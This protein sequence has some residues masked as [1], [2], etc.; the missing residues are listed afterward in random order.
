MVWP[1]LVLFLTLLLTNS[2]HKGDTYLFQKGCWCLSFFWLSSLSLSTP[3]HCD[4]ERRL[5]VCASEKAL[6]TVICPVF[7]CHH[8]DVSLVNAVVW[9]LS[10]QLFLTALSETHRQSVGI[11]SLW[12]ACSHKSNRPETLLTTKIVHRKDDSRLTTFSLTLPG[13]VTE[14][15]L[16]LLF[17]LRQCYGKYIS[18]SYLIL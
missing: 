16:H 4:S 2:L 5:P 15:E 12:E 8:S 11:V 9:W 14:W 1:A 17:C 7:P 10:S 3:K 13:I 6:K 18:L